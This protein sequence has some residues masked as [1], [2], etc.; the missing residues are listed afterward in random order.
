MLGETGGSSGEGVGEN[1]ESEKAIEEE[2]Q[3]QGL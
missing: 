3:K 2:M 1:Q